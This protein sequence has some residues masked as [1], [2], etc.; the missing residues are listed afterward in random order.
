MLGLA[1]ARRSPGPT[2]QRSSWRRATQW[3]HLSEPCHPT[4]CSMLPATHWMHRLEV[5]MPGSIHNYVPLRKTCPS[6]QALAFTHPLNK[7]S[8]IALRL[9]IF[10]LKT[11]VHSWALTVEEGEMD[12]G[13]NEC[14]QTPFVAQSFNSC[15]WVRFICCCVWVR[16]CSISLSFRLRRLRE[17]SIRLNA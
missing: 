6:V 15:Y 8:Q 13:H 9:N 16:F 11:L 5:A 4:A 14:S 7:P 17:I 1:A 2:E 3:G 10:V 12:G